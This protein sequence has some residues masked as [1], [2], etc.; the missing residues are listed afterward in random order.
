ML[1]LRFF[2]VSLILLVASSIFLFAQPNKITVGFI[3]E[4]GEQ[5]LE[6]QAIR[7]WMQKHGAFEVVT[8]NIKALK[9]LPD[10]ID[11]FWWHIT[12]SLAWQHHTQKEINLDGLRKAYEEGERFLLTN[13]A[14]LLP[15]AAGIESVKPQVRVTEIEDNWLFDK[16]GLQSWQGHAI[17]DELYGGAFIWDG[18]QDH[19]LP[20]IG[21]YEDNFPREGQVVAVEKSYIRIHRQR[22]LMI[23]HENAKDGRILSVG[24][25]VYFHRENRVD[26]KLHKFIENSLHYLTGK[27][28]FVNTYWQEYEYKP[29][30]FAVKNP[31]VKHQSQA[32]RQMQNLPQSGLL[33]Q[34]EKGQNHFFDVAGRRALV[35][36]KEK[37]GI[38]EVWMHPFRILRDYQAGIIEGDSVL[39]LSELEP[40]VEV[41]PESFTRIYQTPKGPLKEIIY[42]DM[43]E[44]AAFIHYTATESKNMQLIIRFRSDLRWMW[45]YDEYALGDMWY[46]FDNGVNAL[47]MRDSTAKFYAIMGSDV[48]PLKEESGPYESITYD[49]SASNFAGQPTELNQ[50]YH[51]TLYTLEKQN[52]FCMNYLLLGTNQG[53]DKALSAYR[54]LIKN[55]FQSYRQ[56]TGHYQNL[57]EKTLTIQSPD[58][59]FN[60]LWKWGIVGT[61]R[62]WATTP[63]LGTALLAGFA[64][65]ASGWDGGHENSGRPG[66]AWYFGRDAAWSGF[67]VN[68]YGDFTMVRK[69]LKFFQKYQEASGK[70]FHELSTSGV[71]HYDA[72][73]ATP[74]Y[75]ILA[76][77]YL[78]ASGDVDFIR[79]S[80]PYI[81]KAMAFMYSTDTN[82]DGLIENTNVG[83]GWVEGG[84]LWGAN[85]TF[86]LAG[87]WAQ[88]LEDAAYMAQLMDR[89]SLAEKYLKDKQRVVHSINNPFWNNQ[90]NFFYY[91]KFADGTFNPEKTAL[92][93]VVMYYNEI[94]ESKTK[95]VLKTY[96]GNDFSSNWGVRILGMDSPLFNPTGYHYGSIWPLFTGWTSLAEYEYGRSVQGFTHITNNMFIKNNWALGYVEEV[97][98]GAEYRPTGVCPH[99]CWSETNVLHPT[100]TGMIGWKPNAPMKEAHLKPRFPLHWDSLTVERLR[101]GETVLNLDMKR[102]RKETEYTLKR[103]QGPSVTIYLQP[104]IAEGMK[105][106]SVQVD[107]VDR[108]FTNDRSRGLM[109]QPLAV[110]VDQKH[111]ITL[112]HEGGIGMVPLMPQPTPA[113][114]AIGARIVSADLQNKQYIVDLQG[115]ANTTYQFRANVFDQSINAIDG[116][117]I[118]AL[119]NNGI[120]T[121]EVTFPQSEKEFAEKQIIIH[122][123]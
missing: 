19:A 45:P 17:F 7:D 15:N 42:T 8:V 10:D 27:K 39:W 44:P 105:L 37:G 2:P 56:T 6:R 40:K 80:W 47:H 89:S 49:V 61:D 72:S 59:Q 82:G 70:I 9:N 64:T 50:V 88:V 31:S 16:K 74:L 121:F 103:V 20:L 110:T 67:A 1:K 69:Q 92:P 4:K 25:M 32:T 53:K 46:G 11:V 14:A 29:Q 113:S 116:G 34:R 54:K 28:S 83:H 51:G 23:E 22:R 65:T 101:V 97:I 81:Q 108:T 3:A 68:D 109:A 12:D 76:A 114:P 120:L 102:S 107:G 43:Q 75:I 13:F 26:F 41:R 24:G 93:A 21:Y 79:S 77:H 122:L 5:S 123:P 35:M 95:P 66:Y 112:L 115:K 84:K 58:D 33:W 78:R 94:E 71:V 117:Q 63:P 85:T 55:P 62:F 91:G 57:L 106:K 111:T 99:Q 119:K 90:E 118:I 48:A 38:D 36:G 86:Y 30:S 104:E 96:A 60:R 87:L 52:N 100:I 73:D 98:H 18:Y